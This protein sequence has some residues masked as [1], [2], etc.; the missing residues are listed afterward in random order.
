MTVMWTIRREQLQALDDAALR[1]FVERM[2]VHLI[3]YFGD[4]LPD[5]G[6]D[7][8]RCLR[9][10]VAD[11]RAWGLT[12]EEHIQAY[13]ELCAEFPEMRSSPLPERLAAILAWPGRS[14]DAKLDRLQQELYFAGAGR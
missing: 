12:Q 3:A 10:R 6:A 2:L 13:L 4:Q 9:A 11:A 1:D 14:A 8:R 7:L 5:W